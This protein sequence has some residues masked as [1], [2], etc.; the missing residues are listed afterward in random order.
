MQVCAANGMQ[1]LD[2][3]ATGARAG[4]DGEPPGRARSEGLRQPPADRDE[5]PSPHADPRG[6]LRA[7]FDAA[8]AKA[9]PG[10]EIRA[11][12][13][14]PPK[15]RTLV[16]GA[17]KAGGSMA[18]AVEA[19]WPAG[20]ADVRARRHALRL[21]AA[22]LQGAAA[23]RPDPHR[24]RRG[25]APGARRRRPARRRA[26]RRTRA[27]PHGRRPRAVPDLGRRVVAAGVAGRGH[28]AR[29]EA[30]DQQG[31]AEAAAPRS[32]R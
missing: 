12:L 9:V 20:R 28:H 26:H 30:G 25:R 27:R 24:G 22:G 13:P 1:D 14:P 8:V 32:A 31:A 7:L 21:R 11:F 23:R 18:A 5:P 15:G 29:R 6:F 10:P 16:L 3:S 4:A 19:L 2:H 17:G